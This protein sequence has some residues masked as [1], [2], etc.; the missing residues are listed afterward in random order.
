MKA[1]L[2]KVINFSFSFLALLMLCDNNPSEG[3]YCSIAVT[4][5]YNMY[6]FQ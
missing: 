1:G 6:R 4:V 2:P 5:Q 3:M